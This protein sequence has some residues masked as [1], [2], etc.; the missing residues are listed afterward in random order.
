MIYETIGW[1][2]EVTPLDAN[3]LNKMDN[4][5]KALADAINGTSQDLINAIYPVGAIYM[6]VNSVNPGT[7]FAGT[8]WERWGEGRVPV[9]V[10]TSD[11]AFAAN[12]TGG[13]SDS[14]IPSHSHTFS[15]S[16]AAHSHSLGAHSHIMEH[17]HSMSHTHATGSSTIGSRFVTVSDS[18]ATDEGSA[19]SGSGYGFVRSQGSFGTRTSTGGSSA[20][21]TGV[22]SGRTSSADGA[23]GS[24]GAAVTGTVGTTGVAVTDKNLMPYIT[25]Y[26]WV[27]TA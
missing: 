1:T 5:I 7:I 20:S 2:N 4:G 25:C 15:G 19:L 23:T 11:R 14:I 17:N 16:A 6:S 12:E 10:G 8:T 3:N 27:R 21:Y 9:G 26:M 24:N 22:Y 18:V 13:Q